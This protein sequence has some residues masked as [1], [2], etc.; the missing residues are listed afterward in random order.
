MSVKRAL[1]MSDATSCTY[2]HALLRRYYAC[3]S[4]LILHDTDTG[5]TTHQQGRFAYYQWR[6]VSAGREKSQVFHFLNSFCRFVLH[7]SPRF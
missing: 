4:H 5:N 1:L 2:V 6:G 3:S 7:S